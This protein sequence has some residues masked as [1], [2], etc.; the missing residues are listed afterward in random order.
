MKDYYEELQHTADWS[1]RVW[2]EDI[3]QLFEHAAAAMF[4]LQGADLE[5]TP[6]IST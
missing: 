2:G 3:N 6:T 4:H 5:K 1:I